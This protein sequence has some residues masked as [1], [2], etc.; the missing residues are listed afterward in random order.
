[1]IRRIYR[2]HREKINYILV[3]CYNTIFGYGTF[4]A[5]YYLLHQRIHYLVLV[6]VAY[7]ISITNA[8]IGYKIFVFRTEGNYLKEYLRFYV[9]YGFSL[10][11]NLILLPFI[12][13][14][15]K[16]SPVIGQAFVIAF[17]AVFNYMGHKHFSFR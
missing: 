6:V 16:M 15:F 17:S 4:V 7:V 3:G 5:L 11:P 14:I 2:K 8:Y 9:V 13:E 1:M 10:V 12:V